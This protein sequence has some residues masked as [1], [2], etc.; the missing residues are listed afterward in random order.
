MSTVFFATDRRDWKGSARGVGTNLVQTGLDCTRVRHSGRLTY[1]G[2]PHNSITIYLFTSRIT[3]V[4]IQD[5]PTITTTTTTT[6]KTVAPPIRRLEHST[7]LYR[8]IKQHIL[9]RELWQTLYSKLSQNTND[10]PATHSG[11]IPYHPAKLIPTQTR[12][13]NLPPRISNT[14]Q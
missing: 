14:Q 7:N 5:S 6:T 11:M 8:T 4:T 13:N 9:T 2:S 10:S 12:Q 3:Q 1:S